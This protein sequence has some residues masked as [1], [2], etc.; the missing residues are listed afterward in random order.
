MAEAQFSASATDL[1]LVFANPVFNRYHAFSISSVRRGGIGS[2]DAYFIR[3]ALLDQP[4]Q[5]GVCLEFVKAEGWQLS[6]HPY[7]CE[8]E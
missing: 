3:L 2:N 1:N 4:V 5:K 6:G 7:A 8:E